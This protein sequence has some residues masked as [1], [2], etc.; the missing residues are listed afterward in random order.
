MLYVAP[1]R[2][3][4]EAFRRL[5]SRV[6]EGDRRA[7]GDRLGL[8]VLG[9]RVDVLLPLDRVDPLVDVGARVRAGESPIA[10]ERR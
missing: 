1:E 6:A 3:T 2:A 10:R 8:I 4:G 9:S 5:V 7:K